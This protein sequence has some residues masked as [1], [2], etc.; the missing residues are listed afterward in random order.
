MRQRHTLHQACL[1]RKSPLLQTGQARASRPCRAGHG[2]ARQPNLCRR[3]V[4]SA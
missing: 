1:R 3:Q 4:S 2:A